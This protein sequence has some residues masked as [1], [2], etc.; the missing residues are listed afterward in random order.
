MFESDVNRSLKFQ[1]KSNSECPINY[2]VSVP[3]FVWKRFVLVL[4][5]KKKKK[6]FFF[7]LV[8]LDQSKRW[9]LLLQKHLTLKKEKNY[10]KRKIWMPRLLC[11]RSS[12][13]FYEIR[14]LDDWFSSWEKFRV[15][16]QKFFPEIVHIFHGQMFPN[17]ISSLT[18]D[19]S[20]E[21]IIIL[22]KK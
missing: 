6:K 14:T 17:E 15:F 5:R 4:L 8:I 22:R 19:F 9:N 18:S 16:Q 20:N 13:N 1:K 3:L 21:T 7:R 2:D 11:F 10:G 12:T